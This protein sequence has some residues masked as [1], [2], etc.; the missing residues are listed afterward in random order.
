ML[1]GF[2]LLAIGS[3][4]GFSRA[5]I[6]SC[7]GCKLNSLPEVRKFVM[8]ESVGGLSFERVSRKFIPGHN[9]DIIMFNDLNVEEKRIDMSKMTFQEL[10]D[11]MIDS[12]F[13]RNNG[14]REL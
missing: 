8:D 2:V 11:L 3:V 9:P 1:P 10:V 13:T 12:G 5:H 14:G 7:S 6:E 4:N